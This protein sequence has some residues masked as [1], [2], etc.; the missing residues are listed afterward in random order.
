VDVRLVDPGD[1]L[2]VYEVA[3]QIGCHPQAV[4]HAVRAGRIRA[5]SSGRIWIRWQ[6]VVDA[7]IARRLPRCKVRPGT[8]PE[9]TT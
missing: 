6:A 8:A 5:A 1:L 4:Y 2:T 9:R 3:E 7:G